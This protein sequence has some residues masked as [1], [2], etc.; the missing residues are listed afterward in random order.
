MS[1]LFL[2]NSIFKSEKVCFFWYKTSSLFS[3]MMSTMSSIGYTIA[4]GV[5][6]VSMMVYPN[7]SKLDISLA[8]M[9]ELRF[10]PP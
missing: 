8:N 2:D 9:T 6:L 10:V 7:H 4:I 3:L 1:E 5:N